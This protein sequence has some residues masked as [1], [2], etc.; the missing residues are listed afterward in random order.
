MWLDEVMTTTT[1]HTSEHLHT[2][3]IAPAFGSVV[4]MRLPDGGD[5]IGMIVDI[6]DR[7]WTFRKLRANKH[8]VC[9]K[10]NWIRTDFIVSWRFAI[11]GTEVK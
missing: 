2:V 3:D 8:D 6:N 9:K 4:V 7:H 1:A 11:E 5:I 10:R